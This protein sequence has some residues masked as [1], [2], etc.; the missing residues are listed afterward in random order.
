M[1]GIVFGM[2]DAQLSGPCS[3]KWGP[4][5]DGSTTVAIVKK[6]HVALVLPRQKLRRPRPPGEIQTVG[7]GA[8]RGGGH[9][10]RRDT[11]TRLHLIYSLN[12]EMSLA[13]TPHFIAGQDPL[14]PILC[15]SVNVPGAGCAVCF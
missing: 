9:R 7:E 2:D 4:N 6:I 5:S 3:S 13:M 14:H 12:Q 15:I 1:V 8:E 11:L 10:S